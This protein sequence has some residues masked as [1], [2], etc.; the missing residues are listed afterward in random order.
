MSFVGSSDVVVV[1]PE[2]RV[3]VV[4]ARALHD[5]F[6]HF[7]VGFARGFQERSSKK[8]STQ[9]VYIPLTLGSKTA[10]FD[11]MRG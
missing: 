10:Y 8:D 4:K 1:L 11:V 9:G 2:C 5:V 7:V 6:S 3:N